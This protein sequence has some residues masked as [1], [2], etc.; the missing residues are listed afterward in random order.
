[1]ATVL[2]PPH[3]LSENDPLL[4]IGR[5][6]VA[7]PSVVLGQTPSRPI[8]DHRLVLGADALLRHG[9]IVYAGTRIGDR[10]ETGHHV[11][12]REQ[13]R[14]GHDVR[15]WNATTIDYGCR[16][17]H[18]VKIHCNGYVAQ[19]TVIE[20]DV[21][22]GPGVT[23]AN[24]LHPGCVHSAECMRGPT[25]RRGAKIGAGATILP[26]VTIGEQALVGAGS[27]VTRDVPPETVVYGNPARGSKS[28]YAMTCP[29]GRTDHC[30]R[31]ST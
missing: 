22:I 28:I 2:T 12:V 1:M 9:T 27:V 18:R 20:D 21:F 10:F 30:Y 19:Y 14:I 25:I 3:I 7:D 5:G 23:I 6:L 15:I 8:D 11:I 26:F 16:I 31:A 17:G 29:T 24:D 13:N 4:D